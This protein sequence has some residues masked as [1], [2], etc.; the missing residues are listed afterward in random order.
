MFYETEFKN[1]AN[2]YKQLRLEGVIF[3]LRDANSQHYIN[4]DGKKSP[5]Y[6]TIE[7]EKI[8]EE[9]NKKLSLK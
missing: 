3:P 8:Y 2:V 5:I 6:D 7:G 1:I 9:P 4:F